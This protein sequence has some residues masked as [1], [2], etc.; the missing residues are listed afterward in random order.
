MEFL[1]LG[2]LVA[3]DGDRS[4]ALPRGRGRALLAILILHAGEAVSTDR[5]IADLWG[6][7]PPRTAPTA[8]QGLVSSLR[9]RL[10]T[11]RTR[12]TASAVLETRP[13]GY[14][15]AIDA[16]QVDA[17]RFRRLV[18]ESAE[19]PDQERRAASLREA[20]GLWRG[21]VLADFVYEPFAQAAIA[22]LEELRLAAI[23][24]RIAADLA[25]GRHRQLTGELESLI[26]HHPLR[27]RL[28]G[29]LMVAL[30]RSER[31]AEA[32]EIYRNS[33][34]VLVEELGIEPGPELQRLEEAILRHDPSLD[35]SSEPVAASPLK[36]AAAPTHN[37]PEPLTSFVGREQEIEEI[38]ALLSRTRLLTLTGPGGC[39]KTRL[40]LRVASEVLPHFPDG[41]F[42]VALAAL[43]DPALVL[44]TIARALGLQERPEE[45]IA[46]TVRQYLA[47]KQLLLLLDNFEH[48]VEAAPVVTRILE[49]APGV[50]ALV[51]SREV[52]RLS[53]EH[54]FVVPP[55]ELPDLAH[56]PPADSLSDFDAV[57][58]FLQ[59]A[60]TADPRFK[61]REEEASLVAE[62]CVRLDGLPLAIELAAARVRVFG[63]EALLARLG[64]SLSLL[65]GGPRDV[66]ARQ[67][68]LRDAIAW[69][70]ELLS[71]SEQSV[72]RRVG[73]FLRGCTIDAAR[74]VVDP[75]AALSID[76][77]DAIVSLVEKN[78]LRRELAEGGQPRFRM[79][80]TIREFARAALTEAEEFPE[81]A[82]RHAEFFL[83]LA[84]VAEPH[85]FA[86]D[87]VSWLDAIEHDHDN[88]RS[89]LRW[90]TE[91]G[92]AELGMRIGGA[93]WRFW[94]L[95]S[96]LREGRRWLERVLALPGAQEPTPHRVKALTALG[97]LAYWQTD[98]DAA[99]I[100]Y[101][102]T[103][104]LCRTVGDRAGEAA[105]LYNLGFI[106][107]IGGDPQEAW[108]IF[109][110]ARD[111]HHELGDEAGSALDD[112]GL[113]VVAVHRAQ[114]TKAREVLGPSIRRF[115][116]FE[117]RWGLA[118]AL[119]LMGRVYREE[120]DFQAAR[121]AYREALS[122]CRE[123]GNLA[124]VAFSLGA[125]G[126]LRVVEGHIEDGL[127]LSG[128]AQGLEEQIGGRAP[129]A[130]RA[131]E[132]ARR[133][134][135]GKLKPDAIARAWAEG[136]S[137]SIDDAVALMAKDPVH[138][139]RPHVRPGR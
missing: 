132:D 61:L 33:R 119:I 38:R 41:V 133:L 107:V 54:E 75:D 88:V 129:E 5:L 135:D 53:G 91:T 95:R 2:P 109:S 134:A 65:R 23:E 80:E 15:L 81:V 59:R 82:R 99:G 34:E 10:E 111:I 139:E 46:E 104:D 20:L 39:G 60:Q 3:L 93:L 85:F 1:I 128:A 44:P 124:G 69:S 117:E 71:P 31:Q 126:A 83:E 90:S 137:L 51:T 64:D 101:R 136:R 116:E 45:P 70:Y 112:F 76:V 49:A 96:H 19:L 43:R 30:Y 7:A 28:R 24:E 102:E 79:L 12:G 110:S 18:S 67:Q 103:L 74:A 108:S 87:Q 66:P 105:A 77:E 63:P 86:A 50:K 48:L 8:L 55:L 16:D 97:G 130:L 113:G 26:A 6:E 35:L 11:E 40:S 98:Y 47:P 131:Y 27:E 84:E 9:K 56:L 21:P 72:F 106:V 52:V 36:T 115:R 100:A 62:I 37:L 78:L 92:D 14:A 4:V 89:A 120:G 58:L 42:L 122:M 29:H 121:G 57:A 118:N 94:L 138:R 73:I 68:T 22:E 114:W 25:M 127:R 123:A 32:L 125:M 17:N 13:P